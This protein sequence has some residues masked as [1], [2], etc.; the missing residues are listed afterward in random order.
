M[1]R[2]QIALVFMVI[3]ATSIGFVAVKLTGQLGL[4]IATAVVLYVVFVGGFTY[5]RMIRPSVAER[6]LLQT[7]RAAVATV[8]EVQFTGLQYSGMRQVQLLLEVSPVGESPFEAPAMTFVPHGDATLYRPETL[9]QVR[10][11]PGD[12]KTVAVVGPQ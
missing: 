11:D 4:G 5:W 3:L 10:Y 7:G 6:R 9:V 8:K 2:N 1:R 12:K